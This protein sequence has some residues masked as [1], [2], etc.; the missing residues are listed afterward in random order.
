MPRKFG[1]MVFHKYPLNVGILALTRPLE[2]ESV[3][4]HTV[5]VKFGLWAFGKF[6]QIWICGHSKYYLKSR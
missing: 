1:Y 3:R 2:F 5:S 6:P 4:I